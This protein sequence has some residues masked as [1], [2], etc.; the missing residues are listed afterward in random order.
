MLTA[1]GGRVELAGGSAALGS[2]KAESA[3]PRK[4]FGSS[5]WRV[6]SAE[7]AVYSLFD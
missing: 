5:R 7:G 4:V 6:Q 1:E 2:S 3:I